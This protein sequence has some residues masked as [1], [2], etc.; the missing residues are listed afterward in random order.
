MAARYRKE[1][2]GA[3]GDMAA[4]R[5]QH[6]GNRKNRLVPEPGIGRQFSGSSRSRQLHYDIGTV[7]AV[8][9]IAVLAFLQPGISTILN[10]TGK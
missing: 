7:L 10:T 8:L 3:I 2:E 1:R 6:S 9:V 4:I 5:A